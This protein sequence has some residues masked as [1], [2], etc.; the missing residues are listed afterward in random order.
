MCAL[1]EMVNPS[2]DLQPSMGG[3]SKWGIIGGGSRMKQGNACDEMRH[4]KNISHDNG[5]TKTQR[6][7]QLWSKP[8]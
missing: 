6:A 2:L 4:Y 8:N 5:M 1:V 7:L 3:N